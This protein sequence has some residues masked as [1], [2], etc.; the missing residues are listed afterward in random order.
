MPEALATAVFIPGMLRVYCGGAA[1][2]M[3]PGGTVRAVLAE[4]E[5]RFPTLHRNVC[6]ETGAVRRHIN[7]FV[8]SDNMKDLAGLE[9]PLEPGVVVTILPSV[10]GG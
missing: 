3:L 1:E 6:D 4:M 2:L 7:V 10:S 8:N 5:R 9:T